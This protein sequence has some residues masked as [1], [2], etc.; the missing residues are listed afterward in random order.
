MPLERKAWLFCSSDRGDQ[1]AAVLYT[2]IQTVQFNDI[3]PPGWLVDVL[4]RIAEHPV[5]GL[6]EL[7]RRNWQVRPGV[8]SQA[9]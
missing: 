4:A 9:A 3:D 6:D 1:R 8:L 2:L 7:L 5:N